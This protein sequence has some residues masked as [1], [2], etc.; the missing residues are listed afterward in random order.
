MINGEIG[1][2]DFEFEQIAGTGQVQ[3]RWLGQ[4]AQALRD[5]IGD[6]IRTESLQLQQIDQE[7]GNQFFAVHFGE[8]DDPLDL[9]HGIMATLTQAVVVSLCRRTQREESDQ[10][11]LLIRAQPLVQE[12]CCVF[13]QFVVLA[14]VVIARMF[15]HDSIPLQ[16]Q[17]ALRVGLERQ[18][19]LGVLDGYRIG[20]GICRRRREIRLL[21]A[22]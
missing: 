18:R 10:L 12:R 9:D 17:D 14:P 2:R 5:Q 1:G 20:V 15:G 22:V 19:L 21:S 4:V 6:V 11:T 8:R 13:G 7:P 16:D 3:G